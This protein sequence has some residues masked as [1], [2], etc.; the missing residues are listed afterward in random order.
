MPAPALYNMLISSSRERER[1]RGSLCSGPEIGFLLF[2][3]VIV[4]IVMSGTIYR[5]KL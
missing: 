2:Y 3:D 1:E 4:E 5:V